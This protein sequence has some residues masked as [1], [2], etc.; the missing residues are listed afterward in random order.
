MHRRA[1]AQIT[2]ALTGTLRVQ[3]DALF[4]VPTGARTSPWHDLKQ[5]PDRPTLTELK[6]LL[7]RLTQVTTVALDAQALTAIPFSQR[8]HFATEALSLSAARM[9]ELTPTK[10]YALAIVLLAHQ[11]ASLRDD[12]ATLFV[13]R[14]Q[15]IH[16]QARESL[17]DYHNRHQPRADDLITTLRDLL[18]AYESDGTVGQRFAAIDVVL[19]DRSD[20]LRNDCDQ[21]LAYAG[22]NYYPFLWPHYKS[23]RATLFRLLKTLTWRVTSQDTGLE[24]AIRFLLAHE[25][26]T[27]AWLPTIRIDRGNPTHAERIPLV[28]LAWVP[29]GWWRLLTDQPQRTPYPKQINRR[30][31]EV[32]VF[33]QILWDL[34]SGDL[35]I[36]GSA[37]YAD[38]RDQL[39]S[40]AEYHA[41]VATYGQQVDIPTDGAALVAALQANLA[42]V[43]DATDR[44]F[45]AND[46]LRIE[47]GEP[48]LRRV[49]RRPDPAD[50]Q[51]V[52]QALAARQQMTGILDV[53][54]D[55]DAWLNWTRVFGPI[56]GHDSKGRD[57]TAAYLATVLCYGCMLGPTQTERSLQLVDRRQ[58][59][60]LNQRHVTEA[61][62]DAAIRLVINGYNRFLLPRHWGRG[63]RAS[64]DGTQWDLYEQNLL[65][66]RHIR[67]GGYGG[68]GYYHVA[69]TYIALFSHFMPCGVWEAVYILDGLLKNE[70]DIQP[71][72]IHADTQGQSETVFGLAYLL[73]I[74]LMPRIR[75]WK[76]LTFY[77]PRAT[78][79][80][81]H[82]DELFGSQVANWQ[83]IAT[84]LPD[85]LRI[86][87]SI[88]AGRISAS[89]ILRR[90]GTYSRKNKLYQAFRALGQVIR[91]RFLLTYLADADLRSIIQAA[92]NK[93]ETFNAFIQWVG[94]GS[95]GLIPS[96]D[97]AEQRKYIKYNH[98]VANCIIFH[99]VQAMSKILHDLQQEG[100]TL[101]PAVLAA[102]SP[103]LTEHINRF[104]TYDTDLTWVPPPVDYD[105]LRQGGPDPT[106]M[107][108]H[109]LWSAKNNFS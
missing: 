42:K 56:S 25:H 1:F 37:L 69:D 45:P 99:N 63:E 98:L 91:T 61:T 23:H 11:A 84:H 6:H 21:H 82:I 27:A 93:S 55:T 30:I 78:A 8:Q 33:S 92:T 97:R 50:L 104:G 58:L 49:P 81:E 28:D 7:D 32:C 95:A 80:Y 89:T 77:R 34:K 76:D 105:V 62:L 67:Y 87:L 71:S 86:V 26:R 18:T 10:R 68:L 106:K 60:Y 40:W 65:A 79:H 64:A 36:E 72:I 15:A 100:M 17:Q 51:A 38:Y 103:Y 74:Q 13:R 2:Q 109:E 94:F 101:A 96:N 9:L 52:E 75:H 53:L 5:D 19:G 108:Q 44:T 54:R 83:L 39:I 41:Q 73:G 31:F 3:I 107:E 66:E 20:D 4:V 59:A 46:D 24:D 90:L 12:L 43:A 88:K 48:I 16:H 35:A 14:M 102:L 85:M 22:Q 70:S 47:Q 57:P 29:D